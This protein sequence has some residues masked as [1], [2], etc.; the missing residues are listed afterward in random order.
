MQAY[1]GYAPNTDYH[2]LSEKKFLGKTI[3]ASTSSDP[4]GELKIMLDSLFNHPNVGPFIGKQLIQRLVTSNPSP[5]YVARVSAAFNNNGSGVRGDMKAVWRA[6][7]LDPEARSPAPSNSYG[8]VREPVVRLANFMRAFNVKSD[9]GRYL[10]GNTDD[11]ANGLNQAPLSAPSVFN[12]YN[13]GYVPTSQSINDAHL[14]APEFQI[15]HDVSVAGY[16]K[17][18]QG[19]VQ[20]NATRDLKQDYS[21]E[22]ALAEK[23]D[24]LLERMNLLLFSGQMPDALRGKIG[25][26]VSSV[27]IPLPKTK[28]VVGSD[29]VERDVGEVT[30]QAAID[31]ARLKR[32]YIAAY[33]S[34]VSPDYLVQ[35]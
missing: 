22:L 9:S 18:M 5:A 26:A 8:K 2:S 4:E 20:L 27:T 17:Y 14:V 15:T 6:I 32:V 34:M 1:N 23:P 11:A 13:P 28:T 19:W 21:A 24:A 3:A 25:S 35:R 7:L 12:F 31:D 10:V 16:M 30:N 33:L 29:G